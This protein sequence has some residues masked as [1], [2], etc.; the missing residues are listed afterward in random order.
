MGIEVPFAPNGEL[1]VAA[2]LPARQNPVSAPARTVAT[3]AGEEGTA[4]LGRP[5][6][7]AAFQAFLQRHPDY[8]PGTAMARQK[9]DEKYLPGWEGEVPVDRFTG[10]PLPP[11]ALVEG[12]SPAVAA[13]YCASRGG[14]AR[15]GDGPAQL[16]GRAY[17]LRK[18]DSGW[19]GLDD[20]GTQVP[21]TEARR[22]L[23]HFT[24]RCRR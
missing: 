4:P 12:L 3:E 23:R 1:R 6:T 18:T 19:V 16:H 7:V 15:I 14:V 17:E 8:A 21:V 20:A 13:A 11:E 10:R 22:S 24:V 2:V 9:A 5:I